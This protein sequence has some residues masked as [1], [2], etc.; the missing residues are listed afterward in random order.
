MKVLV[1]FIIAAYTGFLMSLAF[2][3]LAKRANVR[4]VVL[5]RYINLSYAFLYVAI[6]ITI[7]IVSVYFM[8]KHTGSL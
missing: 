4:E 3:I 2:H 1:Y 6:G 8:L 7:A 5:I